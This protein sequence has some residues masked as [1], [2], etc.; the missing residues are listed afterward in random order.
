M[1][2]PPDAPEHLDVRQAGEILE[3]VFQLRAQS[4]IGL[5]ILSDLLVVRL[6]A[7]GILI[8]LGN[9]GLN[10]VVGGGPDLPE[11][12]RGLLECGANLLGR[13]DHRRLVVRVGRLCAPLRE[14]LEQLVQR[15][16]NRAAGR[17]IENVL[18][19]SQC[20]LQL[21]I[22]TLQR[23]LLLHRR[24]GVGAA[25]VLGLLLALRPPRL[26]CWTENP[27]RSTGA[28][29]RRTRGCWRW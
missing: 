8:D 14:A 20:R 3:S 19:R 21:L 28:P 1:T 9:R 2:V 26:P 6:D 17:D 16:W 25:S 24:V 7:G 27:A 15:R 10:I 4:G 23:Q 11:L 13:V 22:H 29:D 5:R 12:H 18:Q